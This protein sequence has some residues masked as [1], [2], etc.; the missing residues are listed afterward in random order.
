MATL[1]RT[2]PI[3]TLGGPNRFECPRGS[4][5]ITFPAPHIFVG[6]ITGFYDVALLPAYLEGMSLAAARSA[7]TIYL[8]HSW[9]AMTSYDTDCRK[10]M[11]AWA[12]AR[13]ATIQQEHHVVMRSRLV[14]M[15]VSTAA[16]LLGGKI[17]QAYTDA[18]R[19]T[20]ELERVA[21]GARSPS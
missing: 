2:K 10:Q 3:V 5:V 18:D 7:A 19:F 11:I 6:T 16:V 21:P 13:R 1:P 20:A 15:G 4:V 8:F 14:A 9:E 17:V 12:M